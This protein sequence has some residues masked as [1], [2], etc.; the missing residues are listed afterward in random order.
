MGQ[1][2]EKKTGMISQ[3]EKQ[4]PK[5]ELYDELPDPLKKVVRNQAEETFADQLNKN[6]GTIA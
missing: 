1:I 6:K 2:D 5:I 3:I 4:K